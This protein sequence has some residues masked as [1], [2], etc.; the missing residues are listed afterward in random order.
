M[1]NS[2][3]AGLSMQNIVAARQGVQRKGSELHPVTHVDKQLAQNGLALDFKLVM[4][5]RHGD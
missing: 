4:T 2:T 1:T 5:R 3:T